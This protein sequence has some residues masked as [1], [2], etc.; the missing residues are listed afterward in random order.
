[1]WP[2]TYVD[3]VLKP[4]RKKTTKLSE[5]FL[6]N[7]CDVAA[8]TVLSASECLQRFLSTAFRE[9]K[10]GSRTKCCQDP[11]GRRFS[12]TRHQPPELCSSLS[13]P[14]MEMRRQRLR[15]LRV[16]VS[17]MM[18][19]TPTPKRNALFPTASRAKA[20]ASSG[21]LDRRPKSMLHPRVVQECAHCGLTKRCF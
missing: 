1:M 5:G 16:I 13:S 21:S 3:S 17:H 14:R 11:E 19:R 18:A 2:P 4:W 6:Y 10:L 7:P 12:K 9:E 15:G 20:Y 8:H